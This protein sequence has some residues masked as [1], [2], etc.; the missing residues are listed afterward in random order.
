[1]AT[2]ILKKTNSYNQVGQNMEA[3]EHSGKPHPRSGDWRAII[4]SFEVD[5]L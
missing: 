3:D 2:T 5:L 1:M 4:A